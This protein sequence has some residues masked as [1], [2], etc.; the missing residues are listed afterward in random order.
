MNYFS[1]SVVSIKNFRLPPNN[2]FR[3]V[4]LLG[5]HR[6]VLFAHAWTPVNRVSERCSEM[7]YGEP[8]YSTLCG[9]MDRVL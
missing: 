6:V 9:T 1:F 8:G 4:A 3:T 5:P 7:M 2:P